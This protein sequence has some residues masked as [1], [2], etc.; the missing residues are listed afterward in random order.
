MIVQQKDAETFQGLKCIYLAMVILHSLCL[1]CPSSPQS[2][3][4]TLESNPA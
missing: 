3:M 2:A 1:C 4:K